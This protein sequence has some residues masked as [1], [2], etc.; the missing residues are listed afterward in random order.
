MES[1]SL[2]GFMGAGKTAVGRALA[3]KLELP[4]M[5][6]DETIEQME[7]RSVFEIFAADG[8]VYFRRLEWNVLQKLHE[9]PVVLS[10]GG[11][12]FTIDDNINLINGKSTS[13]WLN[14]SV[15]V[16]LE[17][18][19]KSGT[20]RPLFRDPDQFRQLYKHRQSY[21][22]RADQKIDCDGKSVDEIVEEL[23]RL[24]SPKK[25]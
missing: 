22:K 5:D 1:V 20:I 12:A 11:G 19:V 10:V 14:C 16:C 15:D 23:V 25:K 17:R 13:I 4:F 7:N 9:G 2:I 8:E 21:Y 18:V 3:E 6:L 24:I